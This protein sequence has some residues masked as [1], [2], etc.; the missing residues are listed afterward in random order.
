MMQDSAAR[1]SGSSVPQG[2]LQLVYSRDWSPSRRQLAVA[3]MQSERRMQPVPQT[4]TKARKAKPGRG[5]AVR[6]GLGVAAVSGP[7]AWAG[8]VLMRWAHVL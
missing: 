5:H 3:R 4:E 2:G 6:L 8:L 1:S 7:L